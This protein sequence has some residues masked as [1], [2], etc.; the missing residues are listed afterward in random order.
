MALREEVLDHLVEDQA[1]GTVVALAL[2]VLDHAALVI[3]HALT[4]RAEQ[5]PHAVAFHEQRPFQR[6]GRHRLEIVGPVE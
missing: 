2:L 1:A 3:E 6:A 4:D 5:M